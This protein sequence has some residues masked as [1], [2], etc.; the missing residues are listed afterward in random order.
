MRTTTDTNFA[1]RDIQDGQF[2]FTIKSINQKEKGDVTYYVLKLAYSG[3]VGEQILLPSMIGPLLRLLGAK[4]ELPGVFS[5]DTQDF[6]GQSFVATV[7]HEPDKKDPS[8]IRQKI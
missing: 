7:S 5:W 6:D 8:K 3:G 2:T 1:N 4:E